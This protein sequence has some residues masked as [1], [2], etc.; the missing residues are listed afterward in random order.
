[1]S[2]FIDRMLGRGKQGTGA[3]AKQR[4][5]F[6]LVHDRINL[7]PEQM[8]AM[9]EEI[10]AVIEKYVSFDRSGVD[11]TLEQRERDGALVAEIPFREAKQRP[12]DDPE[13]EVT[14]ETAYEATPESDAT[15][16]DQ[17]DSGGETSMLTT[18]DLPRLDV[19]ESEVTAEAATETPEVTEAPDADET[20]ETE[21]V[22]AEG[23]DDSSD[24]PKTDSKDV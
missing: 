14:P 19:E 4:L 15:R 20:T 3:T 21:T 16:D 13:Y 12:N 9:K 22:D 10:L 11:I 17:I 6:V 7:A 1:M 2:N 8:R 18:G 5:Q 23:D 24:E